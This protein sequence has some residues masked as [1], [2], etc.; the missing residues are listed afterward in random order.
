[1]EEYIQ[2]YSDDKDNEKNKDNII[3]VP[4]HH[5]ETKHDKSIP[6]DSTQN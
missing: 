4:L 3:E 5:H 6:S 1:M 2:T